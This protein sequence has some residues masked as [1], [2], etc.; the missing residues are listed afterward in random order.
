MEWWDKLLDKSIYFSFD[1]SG[2]QRHA[3]SFEDEE[4]EAKGKTILITGGTSGIGLAAVEFF[5]KTGGSLIILS[6]D[7]DKA[8]QAL[9]GIN[10]ADSKKIQHFQ[11]D[12]AEPDSIFSFVKKSDL[13]QLDTI[14][15]NAGGMPQQLTFNSEGIEFIWASHL[16]GHYLLTEILVKNEKLKEGGRVITVSSGG[17][18]PQKLD[19]SDL[20]F[21]KRTYHRYKAYANAKRAQVILTEKWQENYDNRFTFSVMHPGWVDTSGVEHAMPWFHWWMK[22][23]LRSPREGA[24]TIL[25]LALTKK[26]YPGGKLWFDRSIA[27]KHFFDYTKS[28]EEEKK[29]FMELLLQYKSHSESM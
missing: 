3:K 2:Y 6:R 26:D 15:N 10:G 21:Q 27:P 19:L 22:R 7:V 12:L 29:Q 28:S 4:L 18:Y 17:M 13:P 14:I 1:Q 9:D 24:D 8:Q 23:R 11:V 20:N 5:A 16:L 25:W